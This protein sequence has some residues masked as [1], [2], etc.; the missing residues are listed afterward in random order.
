MSIV[1]EECVVP[2][3][4]PLDE[5]ALLAPLGCGYQT[6]A[7]TVLNALKPTKHTKFAVLGVGAVGVAAMLAA[8]AE[9]AE[10]LI[11]VDMLKSKLDMAVSFGATHT[12]N[13]SEEH[14]LVS[15]LQK[16]GVDQIIDT[17]GVSSVIEQG[18]KALNHAGTLALVGLP[19]PDAPIQVDPL[20]VMLACKNI[21]GVIEGRCNP[22][23]VSHP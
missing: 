9:G 22:S 8:K 17:T 13:T 4:L 23:T 21:I 5:L 1:P 16:I 2:C 11:A 18:I 6:G 12:I 14:D 7:G 15:A 3:D 19:R 10:T 20:D